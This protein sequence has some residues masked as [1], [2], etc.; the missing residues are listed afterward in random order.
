MM[1]KDGPQHR[2]CRRGLSRMSVAEVLLPALLDRF[3]DMALIDAG[4]V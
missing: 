3:P 2:A 1:R 4:T